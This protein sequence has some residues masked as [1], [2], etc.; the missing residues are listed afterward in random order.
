MSGRAV[1]EATGFSAVPRG[2]HGRDRLKDEDWLLRKARWIGLLSALVLVGCG[3]TPKTFQGM[4]HP[5]AVGRARAVAQADRQPPSQVVP[6][7]IAR[8]ADPDPVVQLTANEELKR[9]TGQDFGF[10]AWLDAEERQ[11]A[12]ERWRGWWSQRAAGTQATR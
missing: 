9:I 6:A 4:I 8:L 1:A 3:I 5:A 12:I 7:L 10:A 11:A 2:V